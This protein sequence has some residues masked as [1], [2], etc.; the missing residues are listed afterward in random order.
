MAGFRLGK[1][2]LFYVVF[3]VILLLRNS[4]VLSFN[5]N[6]G[7]FFIN[8]FKPEDYK[9]QAQNWVIRQG[10][11]GLIYAGNTEGTLI[12]NGIRWESVVNSNSTITRSI[13]IDQKGKVYIG[14]SGEFGHLVRNAKGAVQFESL[15]KN[16]PE[17][18][19]KSFTDIWKIHCL[20]E[21]VIFQAF[22]KMFLWNQGHT[23]ILLPENKFH[24]SFL[25]GN[26]LGVTDRGKG[27]KFLKGNK[28]ILPEGGDFFKDKRIY[29]VLPA[30]D[31]LYYVFT[32][33]A[34]V[35]ILNLENLND[36]NS[37][38]VQ[39]FNPD[40][41]KELNDNEVYCASKIS[42]SF[43]A[44][45]TLKGGIYILDSGFNLVEVI[46]KKKGI[47][48]NA[49]KDIFVDAQKG[50]WLALEY[51]IS[52]VDFQFPLKKSADD[53]AFDLQIE[54][55]TDLNGV[56]Y[57]ATKS[58]I[59][60]IVPGKLT[61]DTQYGIELIPGTSNQFFSIN[62][63]KVGGNKKLLTAGVEGVYLLDE[64]R[65]QKILEGSALV[66][67]QDKAFPEYFWVG[68][69]EGFGLFKLE[70]ETLNEIGFFE[71]ANSAAR[72]IDQDEKGN[73][74]V[75]TA[76]N[77]IYR[78]HSKEK[79]RNKKSLRWDEFSISGYEVG[80]GLPS[81]FANLPFVCEKDIYA[82]TYSGIYKYDSGKDIFYPL[83]DVNHKFH[84]DQHQIYRIYID[85][86]KNFWLVGYRKDNQ[87]VGFFPASA[88]GKEFVEF[89]QKP[90][91]PIGNKLVQTIFFDPSGLIWFG[92]DNGFYTFDAW[93]NYDY[94]KS[95]N[96]HLN[97]VISGND[98]LF[99]GYKPG[100]EL[101]TG[102]PYDRNSLLFSFS[103]SHFGFESELKFSYKLDNF[104][105][106]WSTY[107]FE[108]SKSYTNL[109]EGVYL[110]SVKAKNIFGKESEPVSFKVEIFPPWYRTKI[111]YVLYVILAILAFYGLLQLSVQRLKRAKTRLEKIVRE[112]TAEVVKQKD[113]VELQKAIVELKNKDIT[114]SINYARK[115][116]EAI[117]PL[118]ED[119]T[120]FL[121]D[122]FVLFKPRDIVSGDFYWFS[123]ARY[124]T[125]GEVFLAAVDCTGHGVPGA[126]M[127]MI[128]NTLLNEIVNEKKIFDPGEILTHLHMSVRLALRQNDGNSEA[129]DGMDI[130]LVRFNTRTGDLWYAGANRPLW[131]LR[132][133]DGEPEM[134]EIVADKFPI[135]GLQS[136]K[137]RI[138]RTNHL[139]VK[140]GDRFFIFT[141]GFADQFGG[142]KGKKF[143]VK[144]FRDLILRSADSSINSLEGLVLDSHLAWKGSLEQV[145]DILI[146]AVGY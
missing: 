43:F 112:R 113:Q 127:S 8:S 37:I 107:S 42:S 122:S 74:W 140:K 95:F 120:R 18:E 117:L 135:G 115:I 1:K 93:A 64:K 80:K 52:R 76:F 17:E 98:T 71:I 123:H 13:E 97:L 83:S 68:F 34:G 82:G 101:N 4:F 33:E 143:L 48:N 108:T 12:F 21:G 32:R 20:K 51:G 78:V 7:N 85:P 53:E 106:T 124:N 146:I 145:D 30:E 136:E 31:N 61:S 121:P 105:T 99:Y 55:A 44:L 134:Q 138:F 73:I 100:T 142:P 103:A 72:R 38:S 109:P 84:L 40:Y 39:D 56:L 41:E 69:N 11:D 60:K 77:G 26:F 66:A 75:G 19:K 28:L 67:F 92:T 126:F 141:D 119:I 137:M 89:Y 65:M 2:G 3:F 139:M 22:E 133:E 88:M 94:D 144:R 47:L 16:L 27:L 87:I 110:F 90:F 131:I 10:K 104:D 54:D 46:G 25:F 24:F 36:K 86:L 111:A 45:G 6:P 5:S 57:F 58:G 118:K 59:K 132:K 15:C 50:L 91:K 14:A 35:F 23:E 81:K 62:K 102:L 129:N 96:A 9:S 79:N 114:D 116:Q 63:A 125:T 130:S 29:A 49:V 70:K 128:G